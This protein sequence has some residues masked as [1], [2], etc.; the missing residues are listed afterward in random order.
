MQFVHRVIVS[1]ILA[2][3]FASSPVPGSAANGPSSGESSETIKLP[4]PVYDGTTSLEKAMKERRSVRQYRDLPI[5]LSDLSQI[6]WAAQGI[7]GTGGRR[8]APSAGA[9]Y[10]L[11]VR[12]LV[13]NVGNL[14]VGTY[15]YKPHDHGLVK[16]ADGDMRMELGRAALGQSPIKNAAAVLVI[17]ASYERTMVK[18]GERGLR[19]VHM[20]AGHAAQNVLLQ[21]V[22]LNL[23]AVV[24][25]AFQEEQV[26]H[27]LHIPHREQPLYILPLGRK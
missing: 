21:A 9:L 16:M 27:V 8:T 3:V 2:S 26:R 20:E 13:G 15:L 24:I 23:G 5:T 7:S 1:F 10:P 11:E 18:Y 19:Y 14:P 22:S 12:V 25:G 6:L 4:Q 17:S